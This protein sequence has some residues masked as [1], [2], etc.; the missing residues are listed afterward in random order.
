[1]RKIFL[2]VWQKKRQILSNNIRQNFFAFLS[3]YA[4]HGP[5]Q[6]SEQKWKKYRDKAIENG[7]KEKRIQKRVLPIRVVQDNPI[8]AGLVEAMDEVVGIV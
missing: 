5:I 1:M 6:T 3:F 4:V 2:Y 7:F 8:Y